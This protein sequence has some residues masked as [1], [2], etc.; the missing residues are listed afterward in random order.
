MSTVAKTVAGT[1][2][3]SLLLSAAPFGNTPLT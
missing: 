1:L 2:V 3:V